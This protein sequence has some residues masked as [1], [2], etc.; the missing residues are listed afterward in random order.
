MTRLPVPFTVAPMTVSPWDFFDRYRLAGD[1][2]FIHAAVAFQHDAIHRHFF[3]GAD[4]QSVAEMNLIQRHIFIAAV[5]ID[6]ASGFR[7]QAQQGFDGGAGSVA[8]SQLHHLTQQ[9]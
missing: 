3:T 4:P 9:D 5:V 7:R 1:H 8:R 6:A 2:R